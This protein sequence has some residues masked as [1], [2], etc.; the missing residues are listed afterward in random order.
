[1][2]AKKTS[3]GESVKKKVSRHVKRKAVKVMNT[4]TMENK[5]DPDFMIQINQPKEL[6]RDILESLREII[7]FMQG[8]D[9]FMKIQEEKVDTFNNLKKL[10][11]EMNILIDVDLRKYLPKGRLKGLTL[12][13]KGKPSKDMN[14]EQVEI[15][16]PKKVKD[17]LESL[18]FELKDIED[19]LQQI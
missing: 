16:A 2:V 7:I 5:A 18:E 13:N 4:K 12:E 8:Y 3:G 15:E 19:R 1:M 14:E 9:N 11:K 10:V 6:R 17:D